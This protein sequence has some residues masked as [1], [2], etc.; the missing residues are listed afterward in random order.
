MKDSIQV[1]RENYLK[2]ILEAEAEGRQVIPA[3]LANWLEVSA[4]AVTMA[5]KRLKRD[6][7]IHVAVEGQITLTPAGRE[8]ASRL[9]KGLDDQIPDLQKRVDHILTKLEN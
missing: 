1:S 3:V 5:I 8:I 2:A 7:L 4:P 9:T 6:A